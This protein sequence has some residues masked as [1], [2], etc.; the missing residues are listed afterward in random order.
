MIPKEIWT[1]PRP[2]KPY[3]PGSFPLHF[4]GKLIKLL[5]CPERILHPFGGHAEHGIRMDVNRCVSPN[6]EADAH[7]LPFRNN[8]FDLVICDPPYNDRL[9][10]DMYNTSTVK[11]KTYI[12]EAVRVCKPGG[13]VV[14]YHWVWTAKPTGT[15]YYRIIVILPGQWHRPRVCC[16]YLKPDLEFIR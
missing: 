1:L 8:W 5:G 3:Y 13:F 11:Y 4:E 16:I 14:S 2:R 7:Y 6:V 10:A 15:E 12:D 9:S